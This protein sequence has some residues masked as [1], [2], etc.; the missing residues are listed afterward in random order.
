MNLAEIRKRFSKVL[1]AEHS[2]NEVYLANHSLGR[3]PDASF[4]NVQKGMTIWF[5]RMDRGW[6]AGGWLDEMNV[7]R[8][9]IAKLIGLPDSRCV[10]PKTSAG[11][12]L[13]AVL[14][15]FRK[16]PI[17]ILTTSEEFDSI[18]FIL[19][20]YQFEGEAVVR[21][22]PKSRLE[23]DLLLMD[24]GAIAGAI[25]SDFDLL[26]ISAVTF[27]TG[28]IIKDLGEIIQRAKNKGLLTLVDSYHAVGVIP[29][30][31]MALGADFVIGGSYKY[32]RGGPGACWLAVNPAIANDPSFRTLDTGW[33]AKKNSFGY[34]RPDIP[35]WCEG[36]DGWLESTP[37]ILTPYQAN[38]G[39]AFTLDFG[40]ENLRMASLETQKALR[41]A[42][43]GKGWNV[44]EPNNPH[45]F[46]AFSIGISDHASEVAH[47]LKTSGINIDYRGSILRFGPDI[48]TT[49]E[50]IDRVASF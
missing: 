36:G 39:I 37:P 13:R 38:P 6:E 21:F 8:S 31:M 25:S 42:M 3:P 5:E 32:L 40:V 4:E 44:F 23:N 50:D 34:E 43:K 11:Q 14:N 7:F 27:T 22:V 24:S 26:V 48:L 10:V 49:P 9:Q 16:R 2:R 19:R 15:T 20:A 18:D 41:E 1:A 12:G 45:E 35:E 17:R 30:D 33:F 28:Q 29:F 47:R 46:G